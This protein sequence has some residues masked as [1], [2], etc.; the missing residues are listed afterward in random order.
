MKEP[1]EIRHLRSVP[2]FQARIENF[3]KTAALMSAP[4]DYDLWDQ[5]EKTVG[6]LGG[7]A[8]VEREYNRLMLAKLFPPRRSLWS[9]IFGG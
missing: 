6:D 4:M 9:R 5:A 7:P 3:E 8:D 2:Q 1:K